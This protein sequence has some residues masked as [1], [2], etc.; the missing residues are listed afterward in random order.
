MTGLRLPRFSLSALDARA[1]QSVLQQAFARPQAGPAPSEAYERALGEALAA[2]GFSGDPADIQRAKPYLEPIG[3]LPGLR[4]VLQRLGYSTELSRMRA[5]DAA[6]LAPVVILGPAGPV[7]LARAALPASVPGEAMVQACSLRRPRREPAADGNDSWF[8]NQIALLR[9]PFFTL[10][11]LTLGINVF[12]LATPLVTLA[13]YDFVIRTETPATLL[14]IAVIAVLAFAG[15]ILVRQARAAHLAREGARFD[16]ALMTRIFSQLLRMP[17]ARTTNAPIAQ[18]LQRLREFESVRSLFTSHLIGAALDAPFALLGLLAL[19]VFTP[20]LGLA[21]LVLGLLLAGL[22]L[23][24]S[25]VIKRRVRALA[26]AQAEQNSL[27]YE[28]VAKAESLRQL[29]LERFWSERVREVCW[30]TAAAKRALASFETGLATLVQSATSLAGLI[31][32]T[33]GA[34]AVIR[35]E[36]SIGALVA[37]M[38]LIWRVLAPIQIGV[39]SIQRV[40]ALARTVTQIEHLLRLPRERS[41]MLPPGGEHALMGAITVEELSARKLNGAGLALR[42]VNL[43]IAPGEIVALSGP[44]GAG[45]SLLLQQLLELGEA[46]AGEIAFDGLNLRQLDLARHR[47]A[48][49]Y[50]PTTPCLLRGSL[51][52]NLRMRAPLA[53]EAEMRRALELAGV[54]LSDP[55]LPAGL[56]TILQAAKAEPLSAALAM[57]I[58]LAAAYLRRPAI[59]LLDN[60]GAHLDPEGEAALARMLAAL[61][62]R[63]TVLLATNRPSQIRLC[64]RQILLERGA[65]RYDGPPRAQGIERAGVQ[66]RI[67]EA[68][69]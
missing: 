61:R 26:A 13:V 57:K 7:V 59:Y 21:P 9:R 14:T 60:P 39:L 35:G 5:A 63:A 11:A 47:A 44:S 62:G 54:S 49:G 38:L 28:S 45:K 27:L 31:A 20:G 19:L 1:L 22:A 25:P 33:L 24:A 41:Q 69:R 51:A 53:S 43:R 32:L 10:V 56:D 3:S 15:E 66:P 17:L 30:R 50:V 40:Q 42:N 37:G 64:T 67:R 2:V 46:A 16:A 29:G 12:A 48:I 4:A 65:V 18:Q 52:Q 58:N 6:R 68:A 36:L 34:E 8:A 23:A 55:Q